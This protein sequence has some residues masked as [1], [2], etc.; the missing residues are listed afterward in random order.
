MWMVNI[1]QVP[2]GKA[3]YTIYFGDDLE[4]LEEL[5]VIEAD[6][7]EAESIAKIVAEE[8]RRD[9]TFENPRIFG[10]GNQSDGY[11]VYQSKEGLAI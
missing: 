8:I 3:Y 10:I 5:D 4:M 9:Y 6:S 2:A 11:M 7:L 1:D